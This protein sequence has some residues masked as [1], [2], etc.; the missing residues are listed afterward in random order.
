VAVDSYRTF[1]AE[2]LTAEAVDAGAPIDFR[3]LVPKLN[4]F[5]RTDPRTLSAANA[6]RRIKFGKRRQNAGG[7]K[8]CDFPGNSRPKD[9]EKHARLSLNGLEIMDGKA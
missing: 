9:M 1:G 7:N 5:G 8:V 6:Y 3:L 2:L 4:C